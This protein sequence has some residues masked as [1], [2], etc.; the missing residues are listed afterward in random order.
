MSLY[1]HPGRWSE[2]DEAPIFWLYQEEWDF[3]ADS[4]MNALS[5]LQI[6]TA[7]CYSAVSK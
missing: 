3:K 1:I 7:K 4:A 2:D 6:F 5:K